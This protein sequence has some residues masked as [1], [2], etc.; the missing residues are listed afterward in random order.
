VQVVKKLSADLSEAS[1]DDKGYSKRNLRNM[2]R[3]AADYPSFPIWQ[4][5][6]AK[7]KEK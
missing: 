4:V 7:L 3:F 2:N 5:P 6:L 1:P